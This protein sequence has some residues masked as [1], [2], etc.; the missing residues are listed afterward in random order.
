MGSVERPGKQRCVC[1]SGE[2]AVE[3]GK[4]FILN[5]GE[6]SALLMDSWCRADLWESNNPFTGVADQISCI[7]DVYVT[8]HSWQNYN[9]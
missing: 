8:I 1:R 2:R 4:V 6:M 5:R 9:C 7:S 3:K